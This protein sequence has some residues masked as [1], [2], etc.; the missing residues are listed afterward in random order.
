MKNECTL[1]KKVRES[2]KTDNW[3]SGTISL[4]HLVIMGKDTIMKQKTVKQLTPSSKLCKCSHTTYQK[5][6]LTPMR[7]NELIHIS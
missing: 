6:S 4:S 1:I 2:I 3:K 7:R 5:V